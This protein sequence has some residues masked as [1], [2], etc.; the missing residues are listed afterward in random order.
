[1]RVG[2]EMK[3]IGWGVTSNENKSS[4]R[5]LQDT[6]ILVQDPKD[7]SP[8]RS[9]Y[10]SNDL[11]VVCMANSV[12]KK[13][14][15][16]GDSGGPAL[17]KISDNQLKEEGGK[18]KYNLVGITSYGD[19]QQKE[20]DSKGRPICGGNGAIGFY[21]RVGYYLKFI[22]SNT[23]LSVDYLVANTTGTGIPL[24]NKFDSQQGAKV[25]N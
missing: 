8:L 19:S 24:S 21:T 12:N 16:Y 20:L 14:T 1:M 9:S 2:Q 18:V 3:V 11:D 23:K 10:S 13:D 25:V 5:L 15:C 7:C 22:A 17:S 6:E 4:S